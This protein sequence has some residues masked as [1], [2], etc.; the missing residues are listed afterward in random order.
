MQH[1]KNEKPIYYT[2][3]ALFA[4]ALL[5]LLILEFW[6]WR[7]LP[8]NADPDLIGRHANARNTA[9]MLLQQ[10]ARLLGFFARFRQDRPNP[11]VVL[12]N[13][14]QDLIAKEDAWPISREV[15]ARIFDKLAEY[16]PVL[17]VVDM[18]FEW[19]QAPWVMEA[20]SRNLMASDPNAIM[21][22]MRELNHDGKLKN[23]MAKVDYLLINFLVR[24]GDYF[25][26][27]QRKKLEEKLIRQM[28]KTKVE[29]RGEGESS[30]YPYQRVIGLRDS[31]FPLQLA[32]KGQGFAWVNDDRYGTSGQIPL[33]HR[34]ETA[35][36]PPTSYYIPNVVAESIRVSDSVSSYGINLDAGWAKS[37]SIGDR[38]IN[39]DSAGEILLNFYG[40]PQSRIP[41]VAATRLLNGEVSKEKLS[42]KIVVFGSDSHLL[43]DY[44]ETMKGSIWGTELIGLGIS[45]LLNG[46]SFYYPNWGPW[47]DSIILV[48]IFLYM[49]FLVARLKPGP[50]LIA[51]LVLIGGLVIYFSGFAVFGGQVLNFTIPA[52]T[53]LLLFA[54][55]SLMKFVMDERLKRFYKNAL[56]LYL[57]P[58]L[59]DQVAD[60]PELLSLTGSE[61]NLS[62]LFSDIRDFTSISEG[63]EPEELTEFLH[64]YLTPMTDIVFESAGTLDKYIGD[65]VMA[66]WGAPVPEITHPSQSVDAALQML[67]A[68]RALNQEWGVRGLPHI[69][70]GIGIN[71]GKVRVGNMGSDKR[72]SYTVM[73]DNVN[74]ASRLEG[75]TKYYGVELIVAESTWNAVKSQFYGRTLDR[76]KVKGKTQA[77]NIFEIQGKG[78]ASADLQKDLHNWEEAQIH[79]LNQRW[80]EAQSIFDDWAE[81]YQDLTAKNYLKH[82]S[83]FRKIPPQKDWDGVSVMTS[84]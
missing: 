73:G 7:S 25:G 56:G 12:L 76:V 24:H 74:L 45:N 26:T 10:D 57:S 64:Q 40:W 39:T 84:K 3:A 62:V 4:V 55:I 47:L 38:L 48:L 34:F 21:P 11:K 71:T 37:L 77:V 66:F 81:K 75:L 42:G 70:I 32:A 67:S 63:L 19:P 46:D 9:G 83:D 54:Q 27:L 79:Y 78:A 59:T 72:L 68:T 15:H 41:V 1:L 31:I 33:F 49:V 23:S 44:Q 65:A 36:N 50:A 8:Y 17:V 14:D 22:L 16:K 13:L 30:L 69:R 51:T 60:N 52:S 53:A 18:V 58:Q 80:V 82:I 6:V 35:E 2:S 61:Q 29:I 5:C 43:F 28:T 20:L